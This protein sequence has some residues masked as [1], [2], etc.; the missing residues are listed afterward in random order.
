ML[1]QRANT[2]LEHFPDLVVIHR[3]TKNMLLRNNWVLSLYVI[4]YVFFS[5]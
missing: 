3:E 4:F 1:V 5:I 2:K